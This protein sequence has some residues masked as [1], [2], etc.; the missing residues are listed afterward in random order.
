MSG[1]EGDLGQICALSEPQVPR[2]YNRG[3]HFTQL[4]GDDVCQGFGIEPGKQLVLYKY[5]LF[6]LFS[7]LHP[8]PGGPEEQ[9]P[10]C[11]VHKPEKSH[12]VSF[13][14]SRD[15]TQWLPLIT[16]HRAWHTADAPCAWWNKWLS[17]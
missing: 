5:Y 2:L 11:A 10:L 13:H 6:P 12:T 9:G 17:G 8:L 7:N 3:T 15:S 16:P 1:H 4:Q 14:T